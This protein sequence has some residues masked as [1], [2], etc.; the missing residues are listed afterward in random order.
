MSPELFKIIQSVCRVGTWGCEP[1]GDILD[2]SSEEGICQKHLATPHW[3][4]GSGTGRAPRVNPGSR[5]FVRVM[6][7]NRGHGRLV[8]WWGVGGGA[9]PSWPRSGGPSS[10]AVARWTGRVLG[11]LGP[12]WTDGGPGTATAR[13]PAF[14]QGSAVPAGPGVHAFHELPR[15]RVSQAQK[16]PTSPCPIHS[17]VAV[18]TGDPT[19]PLNAAC[20]H[21]SQTP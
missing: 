21:L 2:N 15:V 13:F 4:S 3:R 5:D 8:S 9:D 20:P 11:L 7:V 14:L 17:T 1:R 6:L 18:G 10:Q 19:F 12:A 16:V